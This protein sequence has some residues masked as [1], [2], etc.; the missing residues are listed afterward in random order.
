MFSRYCLYKPCQRPAM[1]T[2]ICSRPVALIYLGCKLR[3][4][5]HAKVS[6]NRLSVT[7][8]TAPVRHLL[9]AFNEAHQYSSTP[10]FCKLKSTPWR[11]APH[12]C[13]A[14]LHPASSADTS[15]VAARSR[16]IQIPILQLLSCPLLPPVSPECTQPTTTAQ[17]AQ[18]TLLPTPNTTPP[19]PFPAGH[20]SDPLVALSPPSLITPAI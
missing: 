5:R 9:P 20:D 18:R 6:L 12:H 2:L 11:P 8:N 1:G 19:G 3:D 14:C 17:Q 15:S 16:L 4:I 13:P 7:D 10:T